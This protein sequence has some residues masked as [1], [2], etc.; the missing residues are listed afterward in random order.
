MS[1]EAVYL[2]QGRASAQK[3]TKSYKAHH[4]S[5]ESGRMFDTL[6]E[7]KAKYSDG[8]VRKSRESCKRKNWPKFAQIFTWV[9][10]C[11]TGATSDQGANLR[12][13][14]PSGFFCFISYGSGD[15][16]PALFTF[17]VSRCLLFIIGVSKKIIRIISYYWKT[18]RGAIYVIIIINKKSTSTELSA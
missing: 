16:W 2:Y 9:W 7:S 6:L 15:S 1:Q 5:N 17:G 18:Y 3:L 8:R 12:V 11:V 13:W 14:F 10:K 4:K